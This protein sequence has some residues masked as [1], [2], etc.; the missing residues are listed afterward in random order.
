MHHCALRAPALSSNAARNRFRYT[1][2]HHENPMNA[3]R[4]KPAPIERRAPIIAR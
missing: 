4:S 1:P 2:G 3:A